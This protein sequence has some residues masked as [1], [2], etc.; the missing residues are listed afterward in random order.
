MLHTAYGLARSLH[1]LVLLATIC[2]CYHCAAL[3]HHRRIAYSWKPDPQRQ[4]V[5]LAAA[6]AIPD[7]EQRRVAVT[8]VLSLNSISLPSRS[9]EP[10]ATGKDGSR[11]TS[12]RGRQ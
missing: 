9:L 2:V 10:L 5:E 8:R 1:R 12:G 4:K 7:A 11:N 6:I 3:F